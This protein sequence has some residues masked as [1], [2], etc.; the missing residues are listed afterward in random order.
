MHV[1]PAS[2]Q[3]EH[4]VPFSNT[5]QRIFRV[6]QC[7]QAFRERL[8]FNLPRAFAPGLSIV[9]SACI[10]W[11]SEPFAAMAVILAVQ[12]FT[13]NRLKGVQAAFTVEQRESEFFA[14]ICLKTLCHWERTAKARLIAQRLPGHGRHVPSPPFC[15]DRHAFP[16]SAGGVQ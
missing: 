16:R 5:L 13:A 10:T 11:G 2:T 8:C 9:S 15:G 3:L 14:Q 1:V 12:A 7:W 4:G 6:W